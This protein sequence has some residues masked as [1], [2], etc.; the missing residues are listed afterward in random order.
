MSTMPSRT[1]IAT[2]AL[3]L[4]VLMSAV[5]PSAQERAGGAEAAQTQTAPE[6][7]AETTP[8]LPNR[9]NE[10]LPDAIEVRGEFRNRMEGFSG[11]GFT[12]GRD[13]LYWLSR[14]RFDVAVRASRSVSFAVQAQDARVARKTVGPTGPPFRDELDLRMAY[15]DLGDPQRSRLTV[16]AGRQELVFGEQRLLGHVSWLNTARTF[17]GVRATLKHPKLR[18]DVFG[19]SV[20]AIEDERFNRSGFGNRFYGAYGSTTALVPQSTIEPYIFYR[21][22]RGVGS[23]LGPVGTLGAA[24]IGARWVGRLPARFDY[25]VEMALQRGSLG[26]DA[27]QAWA[28]HWQVRQTLDAARGVRLIGEYN[29]ASGD[30]DPADGTRG[31]FDQLY[32]TPHDKYGLA[33]QVGWRNIQHLRAGLEAAPVR[34]LTLG[35]NYHSWWLADRRDALYGAGSGVAARVPGGAADG[36]VGQ[37]LDAQAFYALSPQI[38]LAGGYAYLFPGAFLKQATPGH[39]YS[40]PYVMVTYVFLAEK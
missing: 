29:Y 6:P 14:F 34:K 33:D 17:D 10:L 32:P 28:G 1:P 11:A 37:E 40:Y 13:D 23:E 27:V 25:G 9:V 2:F 19:T 16:R 21:T 26:A 20:V 30:S 12:A 5:R 36:H 22:S 24:T 4:A 3:T 31:T 8:P 39:A 35:A 15:V 7:I 38:Q 18:V